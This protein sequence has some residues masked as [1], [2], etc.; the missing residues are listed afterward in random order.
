[1]ER[2]VFEYLQSTTGIRAVVLPNLNEFRSALH[3]LDLGFDEVERAEQMLVDLESTQRVALA[4]NQISVKIP[5]EFDL[6]EPLRKAMKI[7]PNDD[8]FRGPL[9]FIPIERLKSFGSS[10]IVVPDEAACDKIRR[11]HRRVGAFRKPLLSG[12]LKTVLRAYQETHTLNGYKGIAE[13]L[14]ECEANKPSISEV[15]IKGLRSHLLRSIKG[16]LRKYDITNAI[17]TK[18]LARFEEL[19]VYWIQFRDALIERDWFKSPKSEKQSD[20]FQPS[21]QNRLEDLARKLEKT[22]KSVLD[23]LLMRKKLLNSENDDSKSITQYEEGVDLLAEI[24]RNRDRESSDE[25]TKLAIV[26]LIT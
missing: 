24:K 11:M 5:F 1:M 18:L 22:V 20:V 13:T 12:H 9:H 14:N 8:R 10:P 15:A 16:H 2:H 19:S 3:E 21:T 4:N 7:C 26:R 23:T 6:E 17:V 25:T